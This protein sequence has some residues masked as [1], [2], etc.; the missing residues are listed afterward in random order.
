[1]Q[2][3]PKQ[4]GFIRVKELMQ[5][6]QLSRSTIWRMEK[7]GILPPK[8]TIS[9]RTIGWYRKDIEAFINSKITAILPDDTSSAKK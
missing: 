4:L 6:L 3:N 8:V 2:I 9:E 5:L 1:M 7:K